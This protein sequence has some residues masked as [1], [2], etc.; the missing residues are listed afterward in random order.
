MDIWIGV[1]QAGLQN[2]RVVFHKPFEWVNHLLQIDGK[3]PTNHI[4]KVKLFTLH[5]H[6]PSIVKRY[7][8]PSRQSFEC[9]DDGIL[10][11]RYTYRAS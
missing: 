9:I 10:Y 4:K 7:Y 5:L 8:S 2:D 3:T 1:H 6:V 11:D